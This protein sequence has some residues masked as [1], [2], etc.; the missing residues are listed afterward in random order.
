MEVYIN[1]QNGS[2]D[3]E[4]APRNGLRQNEI[5]RKYAKAYESTY[6][7]EQ[8]A[9]LVVCVSHQTQQLRSRRVG[10]FRLAKCST[11]NSQPCSS[12]CQG[13]ICSD[14]DDEV[15]RQ[16]LVENT[17]LSCSRKTKFQASPSNRRDLRLA[18]LTFSH[19]KTQLVNALCRYI[20][21]QH[22][23]VFSNLKISKLKNIPDLQ[24]LT[25]SNVWQS[26][27]TTIMLEL[28]KMVQVISGVELSA[29]AS[30]EVQRR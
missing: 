22:I 3:L 29:I 14:Q 30:S 21:E 10:E 20:T 1:A 25:T 24:P 4:T 27:Q 6:M 11:P 19:W 23:F 28:A 9:K 2:L 16:G 5:E 18:R 7:T 13:H 12:Q 8:L 17:A 15:L 26:C